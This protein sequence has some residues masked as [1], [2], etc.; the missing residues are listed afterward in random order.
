MWL[1]EPSLHEFTKAG[2]M[3]APSRSLVCEWVKSSWEAVSTEM[4]RGSFMSCAITTSTSGNDDDQIH[5]FKPGQPCEA[6][7]RVLADEMKKPTSDY[8][9]TD[10]FASDN[11]EEEQ[12][13]NELCIEGGEEDELNDES[14]DLETENENSDE[15]VEI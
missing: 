2:N 10:P 11:D 13:E 12:F 3:K 5:C 1:S 8:D 7:R 15:D 6:G 14:E 4:I 9:D